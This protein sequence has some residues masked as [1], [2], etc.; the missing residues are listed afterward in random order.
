MLKV[1]F[2]VLCV[3]YRTSHSF[4]KGKLLLPIMLALKDAFFRPK[5][6]IILVYNDQSSLTMV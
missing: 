1:Y 6:H 4:M 3:R 2:H 5:L